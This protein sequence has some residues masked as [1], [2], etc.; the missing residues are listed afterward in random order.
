MCVHSSLGSGEERAA[1]SVVNYRDCLAPAR[2]RPPPVKIVFFGTP[3]Y[4]VPS[5][6]AFLTHPE[7]EVIGVVTQPDKPRGR[8]KR[9]Q[10]SP[11]KAIALEAQLPLWQPRRLKKH[12]PSLEALAQ[13]QADAFA[14]IAYGQLLSPE[15]LAM[16]RL[17]CVNA[18]ASLLPAYRG[19]API[20]WSLY[21]GETE[22]GVTTMLMEAGLDTGPMLLEARHP[23]GL[24]DNAAQLTQALAQLSA[25][26]LPPTLQA[27]A[28]GQLQPRPQ[29]EAQASYA[30]LITKADYS[31]DWSRPALALHN[32]IRAFYPYCTTYYQGQPLKILATAPLAPA[33][34]PSL[35]ADL[36]TALQA[37]PADVAQDRDPGTITALLKNLGPVLQTGDGPLLLLQAQPAGKRPQS[38]WDLA[39]GLRLTP[40]CRLGSA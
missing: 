26:L 36:Q 23:I 10:P 31:L 3:D 6:Q 19:A 30:R 8:G 32:Q 38:G 12:A 21:Y 24:L 9:L 34:V 37:C 5:L 4:A 27:L 14:V 28:R 22:T 25:D 33:L 35:P 13:S 15:I 29:D 11:V 20:Q 7:F 40:G 18:H 16:P 39:N 2:D 17:G 1:A